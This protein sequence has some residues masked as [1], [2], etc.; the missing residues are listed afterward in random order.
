MIR[1][2]LKFFAFIFFAVVLLSMLAWALAPSFVDDPMVVINSRTPV[3]IWRDRNGTPVYYERTYNHEWRFHVPLTNI[4]PVAVEVMLATE[5]RRFWEHNGIDYKSL[6]RAFVQNIF[7]GR[8]VSGASTI[9][10]QVAGMDYHNGRRSYADKFLQLLKARKLERLY[11]KEEILEAYFNNIPYGNYYYGIETAARQYFGMSAGDLTITEASLLCGIPQRPNRYKPNR[12]PEKAKKRQRVVLDLLVRQG[13]ITSDES[14]KIYE[15]RL[16]YRDF[17]VKSDFEQI[18]EAK[19]LVFIRPPCFCDEADPYNISLTIDKPITEKIRAIIRHNIKGLENVHDGAAVLINPENCELLAYVGT[20]NFDDP[21][22]GQVDAAGAL[23]SAGS[24]LK[25]FIYYEALCGG[26]IAPDS[27]LLDAPLIYRDYEPE[28][29][30]SGYAGRVS[31]GDALA[32]SLNTPVIRLLESVGVRRMNDAFSQFGLHSEGQI[33]DNG[34]SLALGSA[35]YRLIDITRAYC[36]LVPKGEKIS[37][38]DDARVAITDIL[39]SKP[40][41]GSQHSVAWKTG[42][43]NNN[44]DAWCFAYTEDYVLGVWV[45]NKNGAKSDSLVGAT[46]AAP[47]AGEIIDMLYGKTHVPFWESSQG[48]Y[49]KA[50]LCSISGAL[51]TGSCDAEEGR[52]LSSIPTMLCGKCIRIDGKPVIFSPKAKSYFI[53]GDGMALTLALQ[54]SEKDVIWIID[55][56]VQPKGTIQYSFIPGTHEIIA[57][58]LD[59]NSACSS[60]KITVKKL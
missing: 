11:S 52:V 6:A 35:G 20:L 56:K 9:S 54:S 49:K 53:E 55:G 31:I 45:G 16:C 58:P 36:E 29:F 46:A 42:T 28:N 38:R 21:D 43:S 8:I 32:D 59:C 30:Q 25:P 1:K 39:R 26:F 60:V 18:G 27:T 15:K 17:S 7:S 19:D 10:M 13:I 44:C 22:A 23:R 4:A 5:D 24:A 37:L 57:L 40:L 47:I 48:V 14:D 34:L 2:R 51:A 50:K 3:R 41:P 12:Y 33:E